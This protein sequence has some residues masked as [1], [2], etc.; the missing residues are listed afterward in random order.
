MPWGPA[1]STWTTVAIRSLS[2]SGSL[3][4]FRSL[5]AGSW[6]IWSSS[7]CGL[8]S[9]TD[10][11]LPSE[12]DVTGAGMMHLPMLLSWRDGTSWSGPETGWSCCGRFV[13]LTWSLGALCLL[14]C[15]FSKIPLWT[16]WIKHVRQHGS[17]SG[18]LEASRSLRGAYK[19]LC[20]QYSLGPNFVDKS[21]GI[22]F[23]PAVY[24]CSVLGGVVAAVGLWAA[25]SGNPF[26][27]T[28][29]P[30]APVVSPSR[31]WRSSRPWR[32]LQPL[33]LCPILFLLSAKTAVHCREDKSR[34]M[35]QQ[36]VSVQ[37][38]QLCLA[39]R[40]V[41]A[42]G[43]DHKVVTRPQ[44]EGGYYVALGGMA[45]TA[46]RGAE[47]QDGE[48]PPYDSGS[49]E[50]EPVPAVGSAGPRAGPSGPPPPMPIQYVASISAKVSQAVSTAMG[51]TSCRILTVIPPY[52]KDLKRIKVTIDGM[53]PGDLYHPHVISVEDDAVS[54]AETPEH[55]EGPARPEGPAIPAGPKQPFAAPRLR[56]RADHAPPS[57]P[58]KLTEAEM[59]EA[60]A[61]IELDQL[62]VELD[63]EETATTVEDAMAE[64]NN[65]QASGSEITPSASSSSK[66]SGTTATLAEV[67]REDAGD[68]EEYVTVLLDNDNKTGPPNNNKS[69]PHLLYQLCRTTRTYLSSLPNLKPICSGVAGGTCN[70]EAKP[71]EGLIQWGTSV[72]P[73]REAPHMWLSDLIAVAKAAWRPLRLCTDRMHSYGECVLKTGLLTS[74]STCTSLST[75]S[76]FPLTW[77]ARYSPTTWLSMSSVALQM[78]M[79]YIVCTSGRWVYMIKLILRCCIQAAQRVSF[80]VGIRAQC[81]WTLTDTG[82]TFQ[83]SDDLDHGSGPRHPPDF[84]LTQSSLGPKSQNHCHSAHLRA[85]SWLRVLLCF[86][87][88]Q[89]AHT[90]VV[91]ARVGSP[92]LGEPGAHRQEAP[93]H[94]EAK[95]SVVRHLVP[96]GNSRPKAS[97]KKRSLARAIARA[98]A[99]ADNTTIYRGRRVHLHA[100]GAPAG[101]S[102]SSRPH[103]SKST[104]GLDPSQ[105]PARKLRIVSWNCGGLSSTLYDEILE[106]MVEEDRLGR[107]VDVLCLQETSWRTDQEFLTKERGGSAA[108][109]FVVH[110]G[111]REKAGVLCMV[112]KG[113][114][115][116]D[117]IRHTV[118]V[119]G[120]ALHLRLLLQVP[121]DLLCIYQ[122][123]WNPSKTTLDTDRKVAHLLQQ[124]RSV[125]KAATKWV[126]QIPLRHGCVLLGDLNTPLLPEHPFCG[127]GVVP[128][129][130]IP[131]QD[132]AEL[133]N[134]V[135]QMDGRA[136]NTWT[137]GGAAARTYIPPATG[138]NQQGTQ[139]DY[140]I[141]RESLCD[142]EARKTRP[143][144]A[145][146]VATS[147]GRHLPLDCQIPAPR[148]PR[149]NMHPPSRT[150]P[151]RAQA[152]LHEQG[153]VQQLWQ[154]TEALEGAP[155][156]LDLDTVLR[157]AWDQS[158]G[159]AVTKREDRQG[160]G[161]APGT[162]TRNLVRQ[163]WLLR[164]YLRN[165]ASQLQARTRCTPLMAIWQGWRHASRL[166]AVLRELRRR[167]RR[168]K[169][170][171]VASLVQESNV[172]QAA[173]R[174]A[175]NDTASPTST[176][177]FGWSPTNS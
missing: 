118:L 91:D 151:A 147:G 73:D 143:F 149:R 176:S 56:T 107:P 95:Q 127:P 154:H 124:R 29:S 153:M 59:D 105:R 7:L 77:P 170:E 129:R 115:G 108:R 16:R 75:C 32:R 97:P 44:G 110:T 52:W 99:S 45:D 126:A 89:L 6:S 128:R 158:A 10:Y 4:L 141:V 167:G 33:I 61:D 171:M 123:A 159:T 23:L 109:W 155:C 74:V 68:E 162:A 96:P 120:R 51:A 104:A 55:H 131:Q 34:C 69:A 112:R 1:R 157:E 53:M 64:A 84:I 150:A 172:Y 132:Q 119:Q 111:C 65:Q 174:V 43:Q 113:L 24:I 50:D 103:S 125:W 79:W 36:S 160:P 37:L 3:I 71:A 12:G 121:L 13:G 76:S 163:L 152:M 101:H 80:Q 100:L 161:A 8:D 66:R 82:S 22:L 88:L 93:N 102:S 20:S 70:S 98:S 18:R 137:R 67:P 90:T 35:Y 81:H 146:F 28:G 54:A 27:N 21:V 49:S 92:P 42:Q 25:C 136:L 169:V 83:H 39:L 106:W 26:R 30:E 134:L 57:G 156:L 168:K 14:L 19:L 60:L 166:Q 47:Q 46:P 85:S 78:F 15:V 17:S 139:I 164:A 140:I 72:Q 94:V 117:G 144:V 9:P 165:Q 40:R 63:Q 142:Q 145:P 130:E 41:G 48:R 58:T 122:V 116:E 135:R 38:E 114:V 86:T 173:R 2:F 5:C 62:I 133:Q 138:P 148:P 31:R 175:P 177:H 11:N 87:L